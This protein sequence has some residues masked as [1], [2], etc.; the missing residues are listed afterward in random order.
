AVD[1]VMVATVLGARLERR[2]VAAGV[3]LGEA[4]A[5]DLVGAQKRRQ[6]SVLLLLGPVGDHDRPAHPEA[7]DVDR[8]G[9][10]GLDE[11][12][13]EDQL[14]HQGGAAAAILLGPGDAGVSGL[15]QLSLPR[16]PALHVILAATAGA[17]VGR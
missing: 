7:D 6:V 11:L 17:A 5:P 15:V 2:K 16:P 12:L 8:L 10:A 3:G 4:L 9:R 13:V 1:E 14:L